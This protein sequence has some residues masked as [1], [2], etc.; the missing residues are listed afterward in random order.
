LY[1]RGISVMRI[2]STH[3]IPVSGQIVQAKYWQRGTFTFH[4]QWCQNE[5]NT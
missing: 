2:Q 5:E 1:H 3:S 4:R